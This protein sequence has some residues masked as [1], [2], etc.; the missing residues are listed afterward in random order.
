MVYTDTNALPPCIWAYLSNFGNVGRLLFLSSCFIQQRKIN[1]RNDEHCFSVR[2]GYY[3]DRADEL[4]SKSYAQH[5]SWLILIQQLSSTG[6]NS[7]LLNT[8][9]SLSMRLQPLIHSAQKGW[10]KV[11]LQFFFTLQFCCLA[12]F[13]RLVTFCDTHGMNRDGVNLYFS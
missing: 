8:G 4:S 12:L 13:S 9:L 10:Y 1:K 6:F 5:M 3:Y 2:H 7:L 11:C